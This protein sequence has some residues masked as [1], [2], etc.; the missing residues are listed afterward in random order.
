MTTWMRLLD[1]AMRKHGETFDDIESSTF[2]AKQLHAKFDA[3]SGKVSGN[4]FTCWT[5][6]RVY[7]PWQYD[8][9]EGVASVARY[10][11]G[12]PTEHIGG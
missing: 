12:K 10:P 6:A 9:A 2:T 3:A 7:F 1:A 8:G 4:Q 11:D 5:Y